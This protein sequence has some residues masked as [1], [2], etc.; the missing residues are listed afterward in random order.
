[1]FLQ[2][3]EQQQGL[4]STLD[5]KSL[6]KIRLNLQCPSTLEGGGGGEAGRVPR[7]WMFTLPSS[8]PSY[9][10]LEVL[11]QNGEFYININMHQ[12]QKVDTK[13]QIATK[14]HFYVYLIEIS[15][16]EL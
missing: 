4:P 15:E 3:P 12:Q 2:V 14:I 10:V 11:I 13:S 8:P 7:V 6:Y 16:V 5:L 9:L 1:M